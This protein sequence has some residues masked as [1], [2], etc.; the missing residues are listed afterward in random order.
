ME[1]STRR[2]E[3]EQKKRP[4]MGNA[5]FV[6][7]I[8]SRFYYDLAAYLEDCPRSSTLLIVQSTCD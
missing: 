4:E 5:K 3:T 8:L 6:Q 1:Y 2:R 7:V